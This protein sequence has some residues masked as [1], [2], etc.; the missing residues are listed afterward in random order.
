[1]NDRL[2][3][4][5]QMLPWLVARP[6]VSIQEFMAEFNLTKAQANRVLRTL[7]FVG[8]DQGGGGLVDI[9]FEDGFIFVRNAQNFDRPV[10]LNRL[11]AASLLGGLTYLRLFA[12]A[13]NLERI[14]ALIAKLSDATVRSSVPFEVIGQEVDVAKVEVLKAAIEQR[15]RLEIDYSAG[16]GALSTRVI[17]PH[18]IEAV[19]DV[20]Y[21]AA[22]CQNA[23]NV[24]TF[25]IDRIMRTSPSDLPSTNLDNV[26]ARVEVAGSEEATVLMSIEALEDFSSVH[27]LSQTQQPD[28]R[29]LV[30]LKVGS[31]HW[32]AGVILASGGEIEAI[33]PVELRSDVLE[34]ASKWLESNGLS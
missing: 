10:R 23:G 2:S 1:M 9:E 17:E 29:L 4:Y 24:R 21:V 5:L 13:E 3:Q 15:E 19:N 7:T 22:W 26:V 33:E 25:R 18:A 27:I 31:L 14:D 12:A 34:R 6:H 32:L 28:G 20:L 16:G 11:E 30:E 8:P